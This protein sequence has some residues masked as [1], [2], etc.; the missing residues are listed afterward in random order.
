[1]AKSNYPDKLD[2]SIEIPAVRD[3]IV[4]VGSDVINSLR[5][6]IFQIERTLGINPQGAVGNTVASRLGKSLDA[7]GNILKEALDSSGLLSGPISDKNVS[8]TASIK[9]SKL[10][11]DYPTTL[12]QDEIS[13]IASQ[14]DLIEAAVNDLSATLAVHIN[15]LATNR[16]S[17]IAITIDAISNSGSA[18]GITS[19]DTT[20]S[21]GAFESLFASHINY[22]GTDISSENRS[23]LSDQIYFDNNNVSTYISSSDAQGAIEDLVDAVIGQA[24]VHQNLFHSNSI[25]RS[26]VLYD[27]NNIGR[28][29]TLVSSSA[30]SYSASL[31]ASDLGIS[32]ITFST[33]PDT[34]ELSIDISD[35]LVIEEVEEEVDYQIFAINYSSDGLS[36]ESIDIYAR[37]A[38]NSPSDITASV[39]RNRNR[40]V[41]SSGLLLGVREYDSLDGTS[42]TNADVIQI[43][44]PRA[45]S[46]VTKDVRPQEITDVNRYIEISV[47]GGTSV[48]LDLYD[49]PL[50]LTGISQNINSIIKKLNEQF[51]A[52]RLSV[53]AYRVD[54]DDS[55]KSEIAI[56]HSIGNSTSS[57]HTIKISRGSDDSID[58]IGF[59]AI[60]DKTIVGEIGNT[61]YIQGS[62]YNDLAILLDET[63]LTLTAGTSEIF[64]GNV[65]P[66]ELG[67]K[68]GDI[69]SITS[70]SS[71]DGT[72]VITSVSSNTIIV[73]RE[74]LPSQEWVSLSGDSARFVV[75][76]SAVSLNG[77]SFKA[78]LGGTSLLSI[79]EIFL[80][81]NRSLNYNE[82]LTYQS[83]SFLGSEN[84]VSPCEIFGDAEVYTESDP[85]SLLVEKA[86][87]SPTN[88][89]I[90]I[91]LDGGEKVSVQNIKSDYITVNSG[92]YNLSLKI[93]LPESD[94]INNKIVADGS[95]FEISLFGYKAVNKEENLVLGRVLYEAGNSRISGYGKDYPRVFRTLRQGTTG[96]KDLGSDVRKE[97][98]IQP[99]LEKRS[100]GVIHGLEVFDVV[101]NGDVY[102]VNISAGTCY[103]R[104]KRFDFDEHLEYVTDVVTA[105]SPPSVD[106]FFVA[107]DEYGQIVFSN[108]DPVT[109]GCS[110]DPASYCILA[111]VE[112]NIT[113]IDSIDLRLFIN[114]LD[115]KLL[116]SITVSPQAGMGHF[117][118]I[119]K[120]L[121]YAKRFSEVFP[122]AGVPTIHLKSG[123]HR[124]VVDHGVNFLAPGTADIKSR[125]RYE[126]GIWIN[127]PVN[128]IGEGESTK[129]DLIY[130]YNDEPESSDT[131]AS[132][133]TNMIGEITVVGP[134]FTS[135]PYGA[136]D[137]VSS[138]YVTLSNFK[139]NLGRIKILDPLVSNLTPID[140]GVKI[141]NVIFD[142]SEKESSEFINGGVLIRN[143]DLSATDPS[144][145]ISISNST[146][147]NSHIS[148]VNINAGFFFNSIISNNFF[149][150]QLNRVEGSADYAIYCSAAGHIFDIDD[151]PKENQVNIQGNILESASPS[152][153]PDGTYVWG[154]RISSNSIVG[155]SIGIRTSSPENA[156]HVDGKTYLESSSVADATDSETG[157]LIIGDK[158]ATNMA[159]DRN[160]IMCRSG[161]T[162]D[163][164]DLHINRAG[165]AEVIIGDD[166]ASPLDTVVLRSG[167]NTFV[168]GNLKV[169]TS[170]IRYIETSVNQETDP[171]LAV[172][173]TNSNI[174]D[175][176]LLVESNSGSNDSTNL[177]EVRDS[178]SRTIF[179]VFDP[180]FFG[181]NRNGISVEGD[182]NVS[183]LSTS[184]NIFINLNAS[185]SNNIVCIDNASIL[186][187]SHFNTTVPLDV[188]IIGNLDITNGGGFG[189]NL[190][191]ASGSFRISHPDPEKTDTH[192]L[193]HSFVESPTAGDNIYRFSKELT[194]GDNIIDLPDYYKFLNKDTMVW[195]SPVEHFGRGWGKYADGSENKVKVCVDQDG[196]YNILV[197]GT[198]K[199]SIATDNWNGTEV[200]KESK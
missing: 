14:L 78:S 20:T 56:V 160:D 68:V 162:N 11:L 179:K 168:E 72:Y 191:K 184:D 127:F 194:A 1:M 180:G 63:A 148:I 3:N 65:N 33:P 135:T 145:N 181:A 183:P 164:V 134:G 107:V 193:Y 95:S 96:V 137:V 9:E 147:I 16:H 57:D 171:V 157:S 155:N 113:S 8:K 119:S 76:S 120:A 13:Q 172:Y 176:V 118:D 116:N 38:D 136:G 32:R 87:T 131:R 91:S 200:L 88:K 70:S 17:G 98:L 52:N 139:I 30:I 189:G 185:D 83:D 90:L 121:K 151:C 196:I 104:G 153:D 133:A 166:V 158:A 143:S 149:K 103:V 198:R 26:S 60:E 31:I 92:R 43:S 39:Y 25:E 167:G 169:G 59:T 85:G 108:A 47:D 77:I 163:L 40:E 51:T 45:T 195:V 41:N 174:D 84:L 75:Y 50:S 159:L 112:N 138:G 15:P 146:F 79:I 49:A 55:D 80:D 197:I 82:I 101:D 141:D 37:F 48:E 19:L 2:T 74:Q 69:L 186:S 178:A 115:L 114:D 140:F 110:L 18:E 4:E 89:E 62:G 128:I 71:D 144:G 129:L 154:D 58:S 130:A 182:L 36:I 54:Y 165:T 46:V 22:D 192:W 187:I 93:F 86:S 122:A 23:H 125:A 150:S 42:Y 161:A 97:F 10:N 67:I 21:Q 12:L 6:A 99:H 142:F 100:N 44:N 170:S 35:I 106:K 61:F 102:A 190:T 64:T 175:P 177:F 7:N 109:C 173:G 199:D 188:E 105:G 156:L 132:T 111:S 66:L 34:P 24:D 53:S 28:G 152:V 81:K 124:V 123:I 117:S 29:T 27:P 126:Q 5:A 94:L 73:N